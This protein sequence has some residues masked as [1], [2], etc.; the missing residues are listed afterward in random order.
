MLECFVENDKM[1]LLQPGDLPS[2]WIELLS[3]LEADED[4]F[5]LYTKEWTFEWLMNGKLQLWKV[6]DAFV[7][8]QIIDFPATRVLQIIFASGKGLARDIPM[9]WEIFQRFAVTQNCRHIMLFGREGWARKIAR[10]S[11]T[12]RL[13][14]IVLM[15]EVSWPKGH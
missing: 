9:C 7:I 15:S 2:V 13:Q 1:I 3:R 6:H 11:D 12:V 10:H 8:T 5:K 4:Y 14:G